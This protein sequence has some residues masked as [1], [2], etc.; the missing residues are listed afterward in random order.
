MYNSP[1]IKCQKSD[2]HI[3]SEFSSFT[4]H[5]LSETEYIC[6]VFYEFIDSVLDAFQDLY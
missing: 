2:N 1:K 5:H 4:I 6:T 3:N